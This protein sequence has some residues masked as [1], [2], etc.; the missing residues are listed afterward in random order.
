VALLLEWAARRGLLND[1]PPGT[2]R[3]TAVRTAVAHVL[4]VGPRPPDVGGNAMTDD[5]TQAVIEQAEASLI[6]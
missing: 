4:R 3:A 2:R 6:R 1:E 5:V